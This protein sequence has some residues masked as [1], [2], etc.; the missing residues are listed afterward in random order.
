MTTAVRRIGAVLIALL[1]ALTTFTGLP[2]TAPP[3][4]TIATA[5]D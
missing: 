2:A 5:G 1:V 4:P 3:L